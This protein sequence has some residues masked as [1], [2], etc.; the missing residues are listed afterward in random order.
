MNIIEDYSE[1]DNS[2]FDTLIKEFKPT[3]LKGLLKF[4]KNKTYHN[5]YDKQFIDVSPKTIDQITSIISKYFTNHNIQYEFARLNRIYKDSNIDDGF[6]TDS[7]LCNVIF[8]HYPKNNPKFI[9]GNFEWENTKI[10]EVKNGMNLI[11]VDNPPHRVLNVSE[12][13]RYSFVFF[14]KVIEKSNKII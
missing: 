8:L 5:E 9:G 3:Q 4:S 14:F 10:Y 6:H 11:L 2:E 1:L 12:G 13:E 7:E